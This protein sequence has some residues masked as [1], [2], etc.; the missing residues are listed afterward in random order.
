MKKWIW[1]VAAIVVAGLVVGSIIWFSNQ[2]ANAT[3]STPATAAPHDYTQEVDALL[4]EYEQIVASYKA[5]TQANNANA[6]SADEAKLGEVS[7]KL[8]DLATKFSAK[9]LEKFNAI[10][11]A[12]SNEEPET[13][14]P[15]Q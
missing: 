6:M 2:A 8:S 14:S 1:I 5:D 12:L 10:T 7:T 9:E 15:K 11:A 4:A 3:S 13:A